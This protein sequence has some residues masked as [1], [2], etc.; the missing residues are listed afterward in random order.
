M[1]I[2]DRWK[3]FMQLVCESVNS[4]KSSVIP[5]PF[6]NS[7]PSDF[8][9]VFSGLK[10]GATDSHQQGSKTCF[11]TFG[12][13]LY[14]KAREIVCS[15]SDDPL[16]ETIVVR[17]GGFHMLMSYMGSVCHT[18]AGSGLKDVLS[19]MFAPNSV[20][21]ML[22]GHAYSRA[23]GGHFLVQ[24]G[25]VRIILD[26]AGVSSQEQEVII[27]ILC[28]TEELTQQKSECS[29]DFTSKQTKK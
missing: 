8:D 23:V 15:L 12:Q 27:S 5:L 4:D 26:D 9:T 10:Y 13:P 21:K 11:V 25:L 20:D 3:G 18:M 22:T 17:L 19:P 1:C 2:R 14:N 7:P 28:D 16:F 24:A 29:P 6:I